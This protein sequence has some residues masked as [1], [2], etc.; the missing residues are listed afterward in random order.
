MA[1]ILFEVPNHV[2]NS[3]IVSPFFDISNVLVFLKPQLS[4]FK[5]SELLKFFVLKPD[6]TAIPLLSFFFH[7]AG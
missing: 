3:K 2:S 7:R 6:A 1:L 5:D 4:N